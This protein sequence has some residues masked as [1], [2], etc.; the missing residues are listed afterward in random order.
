MTPP[1]GADGDR[2][3]DH[4]R[5]PETDGAR[6]GDHSRV[7]GSRRTFLRAV[8]AT[9]IAA[10][11]AGCNEVSNE[12][13]TAA[14]G[15][16]GTTAPAGTSATT[17]A[18]LETSFA[19]NPAGLDSDAGVLGYELLDDRSVAASYPLETTSSS[20]D[21]VTATSH[22][23]S[24]RRPSAA[25]TPAGFAVLSTPEASVDDDQY[26]PYVDGALADVVSGS[27]GEMHPWP[28]ATAAGDAMTGALPLLF[29]GSPAAA[30]WQR[31]PSVVASRA[32]TLL[33]SSTTLTSYAGVTDADVF[34]L[35]HA[36]RVAFDGEAIVVVAVH[37]IDS[38]GETPAS[39]TGRDGFVSTADV[40]A[41]ASAT[42]DALPYVIRGR[43]PSLQ[44][45]G[46]GPIEVLDRQLSVIGS[47]P[48]Q[49]AALRVTARNV[50]GQPLEYAALTPEFYDASGELLAMEQDGQFFVDVGETFERVVPLAGEASAVAS[51]AV[52]TDAK[53]A[54]ATESATDATITSQ[55]L[56]VNDVEAKVEATVRNDGDAMDYLGARVKFYDDG[57][58]VD[59]GD[60]SVV[61]LGAGET[62]SFT[63]DYDAPGH[64]PY[65]DVTDHAVELVGQ[66]WWQR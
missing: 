41:T 42:A 16:T 62:W 39:L 15:S 21:P 57:V 40:D 8:A 11:V 45:P 59:S 58:L 14:S 66:W 7:S 4:S 52:E 10:S 28:H 30:S 17:T 32:A 9:G 49:R 53:P 48:A 2:D 47:G 20:S 56:V 65:A 19:A 61:D 3:G 44:T 34:V 18:S 55:S 51:H 43:V 5:T 25:V 63:V 6:G 22:V 33:D 50:S 13:D 1:N 26:N 27:V 60:A 38:S 36:S 35:V 54:G 12:T 37:A 29:G 31:G 23:A 46:S 24:Y 64:D